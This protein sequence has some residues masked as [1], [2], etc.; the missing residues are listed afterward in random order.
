MRMLS[1]NRESSV[2]FMRMFDENPTYL[3]ESSF[4]LDEF[5]AKDLLPV[6]NIDFLKIALV[7]LE[8]H[9]RFLF[10]YILTFTLDFL[11]C[12]VQLAWFGHG[13]EE[14]ELPELS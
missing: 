1:V 3:Y 6:S 10:N 7:K 2:E 12:S 8:L 14:A 9:G 13:T 11:I 5:I 4:G